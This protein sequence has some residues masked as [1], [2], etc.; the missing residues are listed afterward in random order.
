MAVSNPNGMET[1][2]V[3]G[4]EHTD[5]SLRLVPDNTNDGEHIVAQY[6]D[7]AVWNRAGV[8]VGGNNGL[9]VA[10]DLI[11][12][13]AGRN[14]YTQC[15][16]ELNDGVLPARHFNNSEGSKP[17]VAV[18]NFQAFVSNFTLQP[19]DSG[20]MSG[21]SITFTGQA[22][23]TAL[24]THY[25][26]KTTYACDSD[27]RMTLRRVPQDL[28]FSQYVYPQELFTADTEVSL[29]FD[30]MLEVSR[31]AYV[32]VAFEC[33]NKKGEVDTTKT[34]SLK[35]DVSNNYPWQAVNYYP[36]EYEGMMT[37]EAGAGAMVFDEMHEPVLTVAG[38]LVTEFINYEYIP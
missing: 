36:F 35:A 11:V 10:E 38:D 26:L 4:N 9:R 21:S 29:F 7:S 25:I 31:N 30:G 22:P 8:D 12:K 17:A 5:G 28:I 1:V 2:Y 3:K 19:D 18:G 6:R 14:I 20:E 15:G 33:V 16:C 32:S 13:A 23:A 24:Y 37:Y 34:L 27:V